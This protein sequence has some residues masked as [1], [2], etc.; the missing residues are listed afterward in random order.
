LGGAPANFAYH[1]RAL[2]A[3]A[4]VISRI[5]SD[6][7]GEDILRRFEVLGLPQA[8]LQRDDT[9]PTGTVTVHLDSQGV[10][11]FTIQEDVAWDRLTV[12][13]AALAAVAES[14]AVCFGSLAQRC[15]PARQAIRQLVGAVRPGGFRVFDI[16]LRQHFHS[17]EIIE[18][19]LD[20][21]NVLKLNDT[22]LP[23]L[24][25]LFGLGGPVRA[26]LEQLAVRFALEVVALTCG[27]R[28]SR[29]LGPDGWSEHPGL[30]VEVRDTVGAGDAFTAAMVLGLLKGW[31][32]DRLNEHA[33][34]VACH[35]CSCAGA[36]PPLPEALTSA[37][38]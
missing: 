38:A 23:V 21:A 9:A 27:A 6:A 10:P 20:L 36:T 14:D 4:A 1:A 29:L 17:P 3:R 2:G 8:L 26:Q 37:F 35:V 12:T 25:G 13:D 15:E 24:A 19:S 11:Q 33:N 32:L 18:R 30:P 28:G 7:L 22:E 16:N 34:A 31:P 5:G